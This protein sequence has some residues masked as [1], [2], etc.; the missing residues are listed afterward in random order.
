MTWAAQLS[1]D[2]AEAV[3]SLVA[4]AAEADGRAPVGEHVLMTLSGEHLLARQADGELGGYVNLDRDNDGRFVAELAVHPR[5]RRLGLG[6]ELVNQLIQRTGDGELRIWAH[7]DHP[8]ARAISARLGLT[9][10]RDLWRMKM[11]FGGELPERALPEGLSLR[12]FVPGQD[13]AAV[14]E[15]NNRA[16]SWHPEQGGWTTADVELREAEPWFDPEG[17]FLAVRDERV[18]GFHWTKVHAPRP[19]T[20]NQ[21][22]G[23][24]YVVGVDPDAQGGGLGSVLTL[25]GL[26]HLIVRGL[27]AVMLYVESDNTAAIRVYE[28]LGF[29]HW[30]SD[31]QYA[32]SR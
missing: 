11:T 2:E 20:G 24:V 25:A 23:E 1:P 7:G 31:V 18:V 26:R 28:K 19:D 27:P 9:R 3:R 32:R 15:V 22:I 5:H 12:T 4:A 8:G 6:T 10:A 29:A 13:E 30:D 17:F 14:V 21:P 16:F